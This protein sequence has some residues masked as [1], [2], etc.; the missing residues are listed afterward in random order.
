M[1]TLK[2]MSVTCPACVEEAEFEIHTV[3]DVC[4]N[5]ELKEKL[6]SRELFKFSCPNCGEEIL[7]AYDCKWIDKDKRAV[8]VL[9]T[10]KDEMPE[11]RSLKIEGYTLRV[12]RSINELAEKVALLEDGTSDRVIELYKI[13]LED[14]YIE[15]HPNAEV[16]GI[17]YSGTDAEN[18]SVNFYII[19]G[20]EQN[21]R[22]SLSADAYAA[23]EKQLESMSGDEGF[24]EIN[25][26]WAIGALK[27]GFGGE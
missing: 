24:C 20:N 10:E 12:V 9:L 26:D 13:M 21:C 3:I 8:V 5:P 2:K 22:A 23:V 14:Q 16:L 11:E 15:E 1:T 27:S 6:F 19:T 7:A 25:R 17:Y 18:G 4:E